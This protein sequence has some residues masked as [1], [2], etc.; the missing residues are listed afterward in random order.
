MITEKASPIRRGN[1]QDVKNFLNSPKRQTNSTRH[2]RVSSSHSIVKELFKIPNI[3]CQSNTIDDDFGYNEDY[4]FYANGKEQY[5]IRISLKC[6]DQWQTYTRS[7]YK[8][9]T[10]I[11]Y[12]RLVKMCDEKISPDYKEYILST[13]ASMIKIGQQDYV[14]YVDGD[15]DDFIFAIE[16]NKKFSKL[17][18]EVQTSNM[19]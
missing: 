8:P 17:I 6:C 4:F 5:A 1:A 19:K 15:S 13:L 9:S 7:I 16:N 18:F 11:E 12:N 2:D 14:I 10:L 3:Q